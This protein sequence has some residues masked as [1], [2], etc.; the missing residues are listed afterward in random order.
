MNMKKLTLVLFAMLATVVMNAQDLKS[1]E[2][3]KKVL[4]KVF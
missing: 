3:P 2:V 4:P 1:S